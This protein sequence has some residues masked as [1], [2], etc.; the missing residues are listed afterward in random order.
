MPPSRR[1]TPSSASARCGK[2]SPSLKAPRSFP[3]CDS[4]PTSTYAFTPH[5]V[6]DS[7]SQ[8]SCSSSPGSCS[9]PIVSFTAPAL[10][11]PHSG[12]NPS[13]RISRTSVGY[14]RSNPN[15]RNSSYSVV[16]STCASSSNR[17][18][19]YGR[20][21]SRQL[22]ARARTGAFPAKYFATVLRSRPLCR[23]IAETDQPRRASAL[24]STSSSWVNIPHGP[25][26]SRRREHRDDR[27][28][29]RQNRARARGSTPARPSSLASVEPR[30]RI[31]TRYRPG[32]FS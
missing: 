22:G 11:Q 29:P 28:G 3:E 9:S 10:Q 19:R 24:I 31:P 27:G 14:E 21:G 32:E 17:A 5:G 1:S 23:A 20:N 2:L 4:A 15:P 26:R 7:S 8:S 6:S 30:A 16:A 12:R 18:T 25:P 13:S